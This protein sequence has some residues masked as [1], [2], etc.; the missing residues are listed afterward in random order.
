MRTQ[1]M[2]SSKKNVSPTAEMVE[3]VQ[4]L[5]WVTEN[6]L[7]AGDHAETLKMTAPRAQQFARYF[8]AEASTCIKLDVGCAS[9]KASGAIR[10]HGNSNIPSEQLAESS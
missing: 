4:V 9:H 5:I 1:P 2:K 6:L 10:R 7:G 3:S 8:T